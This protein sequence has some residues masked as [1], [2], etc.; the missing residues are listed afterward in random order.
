MPHNYHTNESMNKNQ[1]ILKWGKYRRKSTEA[2]DRQVASLDSQ[3]RE[4]DEVAERE[5]I[6]VPEQYNL[7]ESHS[8]KRPG[9]P[10]FNQLL[11]L[12][13]SGKI[14]A[15]LVWSHNRIS[16]NAIDA[17]YIVDLMDRGKLLEVRTPSQVFRNTPN[18]K[19]LLTLF[20]GQGKQE[21]DSKGV[22][23]VRGLKEKAIGGGRSGPA[24][25]GYK[26]YTDE[27]GRKSIIPDPERFPIVRQIWDLFLTGG[28]SVAEIVEIASNDLGLR[29]PK[30]K[31]G[32]GG[33]KITK[34]L[35]YY[36]LTRSYY[37][38]EFEFPAGSG[39][40]YQGTHVPLI[41]R[42]EFDRVQLLLGRKG[43]PR[44]KTREFTYRG[45]IRC[46]ECNGSVTAEI[47]QHCVC[48]NCKHKFS[49]TH[50]TD[51]PKCGT[52]IIEMKKPVLRNYVLYHCAKKTSPNCS[53]GAIN[54]VEIESQLVA[55][56]TKLE[57]SP[58]F[59]DWALQVL[60]RQNT[61]ESADREAILKTQ[62]KDY[63]AV[64]EKID[65]LIE[66]R[67]GKEI[68]EDE[69]RRKK[70]ILLAEKSRVKGLLENTDKRIDTWLET[71]ERG[72]NF[73]ETARARFAADKSDDLHVRKEVFAD[74]GSNYTLKDKKLIIEADDLLF[75]IKKVKETSA[76]TP[77]PFEPTQKGS[78]APQ[79]EPSYAVSP[80]ELGDRDSNPN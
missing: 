63:D 13:E 28:R 80:N 47:K 9:R 33:K 50:R 60:K 36:I 67:A 73:A 61:N 56:L 17:A 25:L 11:A 66:M 38:G 42:E 7:A 21:N 4:L 65:N 15:L 74:L 72:F 2:D 3:D 34:S 26:N 62:R 64:V 44:P 29:T 16:R 53:Q 45:P 68:D 23:V 76:L 39:N 37:Y 31:N 70:T 79:M 5:G 51:C 41:T 59:K 18:D 43:R 75:A 27:K 40:V 71:A 14:N 52:D 32:S 6:V 77:S 58:K 19:F 8:A 57:I 49:R 1:Q 22:D 30:R 10:V 55:E 46:G 54:E 69:F 20:C 35:V 12:I 24:P 78:T 48:S